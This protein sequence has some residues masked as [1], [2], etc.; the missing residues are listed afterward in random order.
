MS[1]KV[2]KTKPRPQSHWPRSHPLVCHNLH[3][4]ERAQQPKVRHKDQVGPCRAHAA[5]P[6]VTCEKDNVISS[7]RAVPVGMVPSNPS[8]RKLKPCTVTHSIR[9]CAKH[10]EEWDDKKIGGFW[11][12]SSDGVVSQ[13]GLQKGPL[14]S[15]IGVNVPPKSECY[16]GRELVHKDGHS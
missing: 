3:Q 6:P 14:C 16:I 11:I 2:T 9:D 5:R 7:T 12:Q 4:T 10:R 8:N 15:I 1:G 13:H